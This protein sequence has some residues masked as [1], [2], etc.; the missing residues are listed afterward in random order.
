MLRKHMRMYCA[1]CR[2]PTL[3]V[4]LYDS[5]FKQDIGDHDKSGTRSSSKVGMVAG[6]PDMTSTGLK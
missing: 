1:C 5:G 4:G 3:Q 2:V 6:A